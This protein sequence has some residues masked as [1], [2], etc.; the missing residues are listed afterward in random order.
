MISRTSESICRRPASSIVIRRRS[1]PG[2]ASKT[3][4]AARCPAPPPCPGPV[5]STGP[6]NSDVLAGAERRQL[7]ARR[8]P[9]THGRRAPPPTAPRRTSRASCPSSPSDKPNHGRISGLLRRAGSSGSTTRRP[10]AHRRAAAAPEPIVGRRRPVAACAP[11]P[12]RPARF[13]RT[14]HRHETPVLVRARLRYVSSSMRARRLPPQTGRESPRP[15]SAAAA[16]PAVGV[17]RKLLEQIR[18]PPRG[19]GRRRP[20]DRRPRIDRI[21]RDVRAIRRANH[22]VDRRQRL[23]PAPARRR[24]AALR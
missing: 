15:R 8:P 23:L 1:R 21:D 18:R 3:A 11:A 14:L 5:G 9:R 10:V 19:C 17:A 20:G 6:S 12:A 13:T 7:D 16:N 2:G 24:V 4:R 22:R